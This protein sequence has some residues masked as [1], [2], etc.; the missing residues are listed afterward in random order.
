MKIMINNISF[1]P[2]RTLNLGF[3]GLGWIGLNRMKKLLSHPNIYAH[4]I[5]EPQKENVEKAL[6]IAEQA[7]VYQDLEEM[8]KDPEIDAVVIATPSA[9]HAEQCVR[10]LQAKK[11]VFCQK[12]LGRNTKEI[13]DVLQASYENDRLLGVDL[14]YRYTKAFEKIYQVLRENEI[15]RIFSVELK[16]HNAY[17]PDKDWFYEYDKSGGGCVLDL[18][19]HLVDLFMSSMNFPKIKSL[20][21]HLYHQGK[22]LSP[23]EKLVEDFAAVDFVTENDIAVNLQ[24]SWNVSAGEDAVISAKFYGTKGG[25]CFK[26]TQGSFYDFIAEKYDGTHTKTLYA[27]PDDWG[28]RAAELWADAVMKAVGYD[29]ISATEHLLLGKTLDQ[30]YGRTN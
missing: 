9:M 17:G 13:Q 11:A 30:I 5:V 28:G 20:Q 27:L 22:K 14:S 29:P 21:S 8:L 12:P 23:E 10:A 2:T 6:A 19:I 26:N 4:A 3:I 25:L 7:I 16:F 1:I 24:C 18:G 15:G